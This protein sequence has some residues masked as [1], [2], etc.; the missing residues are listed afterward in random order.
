MNFQLLCRP[1]KHPTKSKPASE[2]KP[3]RRRTDPVSH[4]LSLGRELLEEVLAEHIVDRY[5]GMKEYFEL[6][7][8]DFPKA[9]IALYQLAREQM[10]RHLQMITETKPCTLAYSPIE[11]DGLDRVVALTKEESEAI[12]FL[13]PTEE[14]W[15]ADRRASIMSEERIRHMYIDR[16]WSNSK[17]WEK[18]R[19]EPFERFSDDGE[20]GDSASD[21][22]DDRGPGEKTLD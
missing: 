1:C 21:S 7:E 6:S 5:G 20:S 17:G 22:D 19:A 18:L 11:L 10:A 12:E 4:I 15:E 13:R 16:L 8:K 9:E 3:T 14:E 2:G